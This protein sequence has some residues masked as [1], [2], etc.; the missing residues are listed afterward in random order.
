MF[1]VLDFGT[2]ILILYNKICDHTHIVGE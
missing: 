2:P 1:H